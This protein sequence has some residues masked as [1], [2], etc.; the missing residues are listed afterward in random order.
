MCQPRTFYL[1]G[2]GASYGLVPVTQKMRSII[3][4]DYHSVG[5]YP[6]TPSPRSPLF[7]RVI[8]EI[9]PDEQ[10]IQKILLTHM[11][12]AA[13]DL[14][15]QRA[16]WVPSNGVVP[17]QYAV[18]EVVCSPATLCNFNLDGL[19][20]LH[21]GHR[22]SVIEMHGRIDR[23]W[24]ERAN[25]RELLEAAVIDEIPIPHLSPKLLPQ[26][27]PTDTTSHPNYTRAQQ[28]FHL[29]RA[30]IILGYSFGQRSDG[31]DDTQSFEFFVSLMRCHPRPVFVV[32]LTP[33]DL[34]EMLRDRLSSHHVYGISLRWELFSGAVLANA[35]PVQ[36]L[37]TNWLDK[38]LEGVIRAYETALDSV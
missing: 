37:R 25:Y 32:S 12:P 24:F 15:A 7:K 26:P 13:L 3:E 9:S 27:E 31:F 5:V 21:C 2:A 36:G 22:H 38:K 1:L 28:L 30:V 8:G 14:L 33:H 6:T 23:P 19:A 17:S 4:S 10:D 20:S 34:A 11:P 29:A 16:L 18:F 35:D